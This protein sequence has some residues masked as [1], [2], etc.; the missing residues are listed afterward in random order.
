LNEKRKEIA[1]RNKIETRKTQN[2][3]TSRQWEHSNITSVATLLMFI[4]HPKYCPPFQE[5]NLVNS[6]SKVYLLRS[7]NWSDIANFLD[8]TSQNHTKL[9]KLLQINF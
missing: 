5:S 4:S 9:T 8:N 7:T 6:Y 1:D 3:H 2:V